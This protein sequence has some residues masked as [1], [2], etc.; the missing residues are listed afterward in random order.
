MSQLVTVNINHSLGVDGARSR[1]QSALDDFRG[2]IGGQL[3]V[4]DTSWTGNHLD[5]KIG[6]MGH[7]LSGGLDVFE[8]CVRLEVAL[9][10]A[11]GFF[12]KKIQSLIKK[13]GRLLLIKS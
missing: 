12:A 10:G 2:L 8:F 11:L 5:F 3:S 13:R 6:F 1:I 9:P 7:T 4:Y